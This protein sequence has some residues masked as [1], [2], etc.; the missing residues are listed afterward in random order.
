MWRPMRVILVSSD[1]RIFKRNV[2]G[3][4]F[5]EPFSRGLLVGEDLEMVATFCLLVS[6]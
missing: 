2:L 3:I 1:H 6:T 5:R 4:I